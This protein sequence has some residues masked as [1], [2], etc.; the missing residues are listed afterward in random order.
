MFRKVVQE[1]RRLKDL[2]NG[3]GYGFDPIV[4]ERKID[5]QSINQNQK[6]K[7]MMIKELYDAF[8]D[9]DGTQSDLDHNEKNDEVGVRK[10]KNIEMNDV[11]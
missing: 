8:G 5:E 4:G 11:F 1:V 7:K 3:N 2:S 6:K 9:S 10:K